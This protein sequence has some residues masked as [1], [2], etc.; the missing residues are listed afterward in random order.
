VKTKK[1]IKEEYKSL[2]FRVG[3]FQ[4]TNKKDNRI[5]LKTSSDLDRAFNSDLFQLNAGMHSNQQLQS[6]WNNLGAE[7][8]TFIIFDEL[9]IKD[10]ETPTDISQ[11]L[12]ELLEIHLSELKS[13]GQ[14]IY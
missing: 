7:N 9:K 3:I 4:I 2:K 6:D 12:K 13:K 11:E 8:F 14:L 1:E 10:S 5:F